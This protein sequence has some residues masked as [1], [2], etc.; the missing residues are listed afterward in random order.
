VPQEGAE[1]GADGCSDFLQ[2]E[3]AEVPVPE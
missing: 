2:G 3:T 1:T